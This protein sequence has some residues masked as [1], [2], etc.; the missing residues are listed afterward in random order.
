MEFQSNEEQVIMYFH[1][2]ASKGPDLESFSKI[3]DSIYIFIFCSFI[4]Q[5]ISI[6][7]IIIEELSA[8]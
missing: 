4:I 7:I 2:L 8:D 5:S 3:A 6:V 1:G